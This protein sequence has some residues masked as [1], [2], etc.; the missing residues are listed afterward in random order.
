MRKFKYLLVSL[1]LILTVSCN[2]EKEVKPINFNIFWEQTLS[3]L[4]KEPINFEKISKDSI[5]DGKIISL[6]KISSFQNIFFYAWVSE[7]IEKG[8][9]PIKIRFSGLDGSHTIR[10]EIKNFWFLKQKGFINMLVDVRGQGLSTEQINPKEYI[11][12]RINKKEE[13]IYRGA[14]MD[15]VRSVDFISENKKSNG[16]IIV[17][18]GSQGAALSIAATAL[19]NKV[20][21]CII[22]F[23]FLTDIPAYDKT[24]WP[25]KIFL[26]KA[27]S[28]QI[29]YFDLKNTL[30]YF[31]MLNFAEKINIPVFLRTEEYDEITPKEGAIKF[32]NLLKNQKKVLYI[33]PCKGHGCSSTSVVANE[34]EKIFIRDYLKSKKD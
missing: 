7:P 2:N 12:D 26:H 13:F 8:E 28:K 33:E 17:T 31:D 29:D 32:F 23:P 14:F 20:N 10:N 15:A 18:G 16:K 22:G 19:N 9:F 11:T 6:F 1:T 34:M 24:K 3:E 4:N 21:L 25:M 30:S 5:V 27:K